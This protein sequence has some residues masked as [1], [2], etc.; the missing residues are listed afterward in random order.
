MTKFDAMFP[1]VGT[2]CSDEDIAK[3]MATLTKA[4]HGTGKEDLAKNLSLATASLEFKFG[5]N[6]GLTVHNS[7]GEI[8]DGNYS[9][10]EIA[11]IFSNNGRVMR[12]LKDCVQ[13]FDMQDAIMIPKLVDKTLADN[14]GKWAEPTTDMLKDVKTLTLDA[15]KEYTSDTLKFDKAMELAVK[16]SIGF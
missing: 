15:V 16:T 5:V 3:E 13:Q 8:E 10:N 12:C 6:N 11:D 7:S 9:S 2:P 1:S 4:N 14:S